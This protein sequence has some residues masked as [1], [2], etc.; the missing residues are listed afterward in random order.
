[1]SVIQAVRGTKDIL[2]DEILKWHKLEE[3]ARKVS[4]NYGYKELR[5]PIFEKTEVFTRG[6]GNGTDIV[7]KEMY[8][9][10]DRGDESITLRPEQTAAIVRA[11]IQNN[12]LKENSTTRLYYIGQYF[13][14]E[15]PQKGRLR[16]FHQYGAECINSPYPESDA[17]VICLAVSLI[18][19]L[20]ITDYKL[21]LNSLGNEISR[22]NYRNVLIN[23]LES[24]KEK[25]SEESKVRLATNPLRILDSKNPI[26][27]EITTKA[28]NILD[29]LDN[30]SI[31][32]FDE[33]KKLL[34]ASDINYEISPNLV[35]GL[36]YYSHTVFE[37]QSTYLG[38]Q[39]AFAGGGRYNS[40]FKEL[41]GKDT[42]AVGFAMGIE[43]LLLILEQIE[44]QKIENLKDLIN[45]IIVPTSEKHLDTAMRVANIIRNKLELSC[46]VDVNR[47]SMKS[48]LR[49]GNKWE[50]MRA[51]IIGDDEVATDSVTVKYMMEK[52]EQYSLKIEDIV[53]QNW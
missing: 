28:P 19:K 15:R 21:R 29:S 7:N 52:I 42:P 20:G 9:F 27:I 30:E 50:V 4:A 53:K 31:E 39:D 47:R 1:M 18:N 45:V 22:A 17:E 44:Q 46:L 43:R 41:G 5:T 2:P 40:L 26:D 35:R 14:Y 49:E 16:E 32:H 8:S 33:V 38:A 48:Q 11:V 12:L 34:T 10:L 3:I 51:L 6:V 24:N 25:L 13:R 23:F 37:F 36:D